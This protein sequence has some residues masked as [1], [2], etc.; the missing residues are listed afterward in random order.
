MEEKASLKELDQ[1]IEQLNDCKQ[2]T[3]SQVKTLCDKV[4]TSLQE[5]TVFLNSYAR[6]RPAFLQPV[7]S[8]SR[9]LSLSLAIADLLRSL[10]VSISSPSHIAPKRNGWTGPRY[11]RSLHLFSR[12][13]SLFAWSRPGTK[14][15][16]LFRARDTFLLYA[17]A[18][19]L[20][21]YANRAIDTSLS[22]ALAHSRI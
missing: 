21:F 1:W 3:E 20:F 16:S 2:L 6:L 13:P 10:F 8:A 9:S 14:L 15:P 22:L 4:S 5:T 12:S 18:V 7:D 17:A 19:S 11:S